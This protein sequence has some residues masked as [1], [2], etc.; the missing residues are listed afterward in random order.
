MKIF[1]IVSVFALAAAMLLIASAMPSFAQTSTS[2]APISLKVKTPKPKQVWLK[3]EVI[4]ADTQSMIVRDP[5]N[6]LM[7]HTFTYSP[8]VRGQIERIIETGGYQYGDQVKIRCIDGQTVALALK[9]K[10]SKPI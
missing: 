9:G 4:H 10:P 8:K 1:R 2:A 6:P 7:I 5:S 3:A